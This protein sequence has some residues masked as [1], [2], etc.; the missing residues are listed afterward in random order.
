[1][2]RVHESE[3]AAAAVKYL[4]EGLVRGDYYSRGAETEG[5]Y[6]GKGAER[7]GL[8]GAVRDEDFTALVNNRN[9]K[10]G[11]KLTARDKKN[12]RPGYDAVLSAWKS[13]AV[14]EGV[15]GCGDIRGAFVYAGDQMMTQA[16]EPLMHT[17]VR[18]DGQDHD[19]VTGEM[20]G[21]GYL[22]GESRPVD[23]RP[24]PHLHKH[25]Y[26]LNATWD[27]T[28]QR[29]KA[30]QFG[31]LKEKGPELELDFDARFAIQLRDLGYVPVL[32]KNGVQIK[33]VPQ[34]V[35][36]KFSRNSKRIE[37]ES[38]IRGVTDGVGKHRV[39][40]KL[41]EKKRDGLT[42]SEMETEWNTRLTPEEREA[43]RKVKNKEIEAGPEIT[44][45]EATQYAIG[46]LFQREDVVTE[47]KLRKT[48]LHYGIGDMMPA[49]VDREISAAL[50]RGEILAKDGKK[51]R[52]FAKT[53]T[54][55]DQSRMTQLARDGIG[56]CEPLTKAYQDV[57]ELSAEQNAAA[58]MVAE[59]RDRYMG[60]RGPAGT[61]K[62]YTLK[63]VAAVI[64][65]RK[66][67]GEEK[68]NRVLLLAPSTSA[69]RGEGRKAG[70][71]DA[72]TLAAFFGSEKM[73]RDMQGQFL[74]VDESG[75]MST[76]DMVQL[77]AI[78]EQHDNRVLFV[79]D[80]KQHASV[81]AGDAFRL[82]QSEGGLKYAVLTENRRQK[83]AGHRA[84]VDAM[85][86]G[87]RDGVLRGF[88]MLDRLG[89]VVVEA[90]RDKVRRK[91]AAAYLKSADEGKSAV[92]ITPT[93]AEA[94]YLTGELRSALKERG[95][96]CWRRTI[97]SQAR[98]DDVDGRAKAGRAQ[99]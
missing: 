13:A 11:K 10:T 23:G 75:M 55:R 63:A 37:K 3:S 42:R 51:G 31:L 2:L 70:Y 43:L 26:L 5:R 30:G 24:D 73:Q 56:Q 85:A 47:R 66:A 74:M 40:D 99:L 84:A 69:S 53:S 20:V 95:A 61:G 62:S 89:A 7:L 81:D 60:L 97:G 52:K 39:A 22:H 27:S 93:H 49:D 83:S 12:K 44:P 88:D 32:G 1:M 19:R 15:M 36:D 71:K 28:E 18:I 48:A 77:M 14:M 50:E 21:M 92:I 72:T 82:L 6:I 45:Y 68:Y 41:R 38:A 87:T 35:I 79:G 80:Y 34:S 67:R 59:S 64:E 57:E 9:P 91:I 94:E 8:S 17:R 46:H 58:R 33:G 29:W 86:E 25:Y 65:E 90:D 78:A 96:D 76:T 4:R 98:G 16:A 54:F